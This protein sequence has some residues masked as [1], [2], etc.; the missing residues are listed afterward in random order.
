[1][2]KHY[3]DGRPAEQDGRQVKYDAGGSPHFVGGQPEAVSAVVMHSKFRVE[4][5]KVGRLL[6]AIAAALTEAEDE[7]ATRTAAFL[8][9]TLIAET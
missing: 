6:T 8:R 4:E 2:S 7:H 9:E 1:M 5:A 3:A